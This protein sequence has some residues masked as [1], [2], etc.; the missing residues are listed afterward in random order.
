MK[1]LVI[2]SNRGPVQHRKTDAGRVADRGPGGLVSALSSLPALGVGGVW[3]CA[4][5]SEA[6]REVAAESDG[7]A[8]D[9]PSY[10]Q[11]SMRVRMIEHDPEVFEDAHHG[12]SNSLLWFLQHQLW[13]W[14]SDPTIGPSSYESFEA[15][16]AVNQTFADAAAEEVRRL[17]ASDEA[18]AVM[19][20]DYH[21]YLAPGMVRAQVP[22]AVIQLFVHIPWP[23]FDA[24]RALPRTFVEDILRGLLGCDVV[25]FQTEHYA[26]C[27]IQTA[28]HYL[29]LPL[30]SAGNLVAPDGRIV[31]VAWYPISVDVDSISA[32]TREGVTRIEREELAAR[33]TEKLIVRVDRADPSKNIYRGFQAYELMLELYP[34]WFARVGFHA[35]VQPSR[36]NIPIYADYL[37][38]LE[39]IA[40]RIN[41]RFGTRTWTPVTLIVGESL[42]RAVAA[43]QEYDVLLVNPVADGLNLVAKEGV[44][45]NERAG[46]LVLSETAGVYEEIGAF[47]LGVN[48]F[49]ILDQAQTLHR[50]LS[51]PEDQRRALAMACKEVVLRNDLDRWLGEQLRDL[52]RIRSTRAS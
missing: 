38:Q 50:A 15:Y 2:V 12:F 42:P 7:R 30:D 47:T 5:L 48:P 32:I 44:L 49:D 20:H 23:A 18:P 41:D 21:L 26:Q 31:R 1:R 13:G 24:W 4:A 39:A 17:S 29:G 27:F 37:E 40:K 34:E 46:V 6:D 33:R 45:V 9:V 11:G 22:E 28:Q 16:R 3:V 51:M 10:A 36:S 52:D 43:F 8:I 25:A 14:G 35:L 19:L